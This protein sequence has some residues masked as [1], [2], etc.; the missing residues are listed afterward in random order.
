MAVV[1]VACLIGLVAVALALLWDQPVADR[2]RAPDWDPLPAPVDV[3]RVE[4]PLAF[5]GYDPAT[6]EVTLET[7]NDAYADL[8]AVAP[9]AVVER[10]RRRAALRAGREPAEAATVPPAPVPWSPVTGR[11]DDREALRAEAALAAVGVLA[12][13][14]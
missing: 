6:V 7:L 5:P 4:F 11:I 8:L 13:Q 2:L 9:P 12:R 1:A 14:R 10:A 3:S